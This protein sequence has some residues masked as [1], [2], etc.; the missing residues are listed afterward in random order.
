[1]E[2]S[3][4]I[5]VSKM[6]DSHLKEQIEAVFI[7]VFNVKG[8]KVTLEEVATSIHISKKT[9]YRFFKSK[10]DIYESILHDT[11][12]E[13]L[14]E[15]RRIFN[16]PNLST[17]EKL[18][19]ILTI[20]TTAEQQMDVA[21][22]NLLKDTD[23]IFYADL[24]KGYETQWQYFADLIEIAKKDGTV[25]PDTSAPFL[26]NIFSRAYESFYMN[27]FLS[28]N[29]MTYTEAVTRIALITLDGALIH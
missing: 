8:P 19:A 13:I 21:K 28:R 14:S 7:A 16:D 23:P 5:W 20:K 11:M 18:L 2:T 27:D 15:Q 6:L 1:M 17:R 25:K 10:T 26:I 24:I 29:H 12:K 9:I 22:M 4:K 3:F